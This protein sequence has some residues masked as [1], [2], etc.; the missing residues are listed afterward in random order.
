M[1]YHLFLLLSFFVICCCYLNLINLD[2]LEDRPYKSACRGMSQSTAQKS[3][4]DGDQGRVS[5][6][7]AELQGTVHL[8]FEHIKVDPVQEDIARHGCTGSKGGPLPEVV[9]GVQTE[10][11]HD[12]GR[13]AN[14]NG[15]NGI[16]TKQEAVHVVE[17]VVPERGQNV[18]QL[19]K[20]RAETQE[21]GKGNQARGLSVPGHVLWDRSRDGID[22]AREAGGGAGTGMAS[23]EGSDDT[24]RNRHENI[25]EEKLEDYH[26]GDRVDGAVR[27]RNNVQDDENQARHHRKEHDGETHGGLPEIAR[28]RVLSASGNRWVVFLKVSSRRVPANDRRECVAN[29]DG[30]HH[31]TAFFVDFPVDGS[32]NRK[33][34]DSEGENNELASGTNE[35]SKQRQHGGGA[36]DVAVDLLPSGVLDLVVH[37]G[38]LFV[39]VH[40]SVLQVVDQ[41]VTGVV[42]LQRPEKNQ[43]DESHQEQ[44]H[45]ERVEDRKPMDGVLEKF[46]IEVSIEPRVEFFGCRFELDVEGEIQ[47]SAFCHQHQRLRVAG[48]IDLHD[49]V[50]VIGDDQVSCGV[51]IRMEVTDL[52][53]VQF[54]HVIET[55]QVV[56]F[57]QFELIDLGKHLTDH[58]PDRQ[59][60]EVHLVKPTML[61]SSGELIGLRRGQGFGGARLRLFRLAQEE[62]V[63]TGMAQGVASEVFTHGQRLPFVPATRSIAVL[64]VVFGIRSTVWEFVIFISFLRVSVRTNLVDP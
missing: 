36:E 43:C 27:E 12:D 7:E 37:H 55:F 46:V 62:N 58:S 38:F 1:G 22:P 40:F 53:I 32:K 52:G 50:S 60:V 48:E 54:R 61:N 6:I 33:E 56:L 39:V 9:F 26:E 45:H 14:H 34:N 18:V 59:V 24:E 3:H 23:Q 44:H 31:F 5:E 25:K 42:L 63:V 51:D 4:V 8:G 57:F 35:G 17:L 47:L 30:L 28:S 19:N 2:V 11:N 41:S 29:K 20:D 16:D 15:K 49:L 13:H 10:V 21:S 64:G